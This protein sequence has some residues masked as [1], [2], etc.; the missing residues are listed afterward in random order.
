MIWVLL[1][2][3][4]RSDASSSNFKVA[5]RGL[6]CGNGSLQEAAARWRIEVS[7]D[8]S[9]LHPDLIL[10]PNNLDHFVTKAR[11]GTR[12]FLPVFERNAIGHDICHVVSPLSYLFY[13][14]RNQLC[15]ISLKNF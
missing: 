4:R 2:A 3:T 15:K 11:S 9:L 12:R 6:G 1:A 8:A 7:D 10:V 13:N 14:P 5:Q